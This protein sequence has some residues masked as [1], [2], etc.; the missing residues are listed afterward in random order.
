MILV[1]A[2]ITSKSGDRNKIISKSKDLI[3]S[4]RLESG[5]INYDLYESIEDVDVLLV[6]EQWKDK[7]ALELHLQTEHFKAFGAAIEEFLDKEMDIVIYSAE[8]V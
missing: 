1:T 6:L 3:E 5:C 2:K 8:K 7:E 4:S